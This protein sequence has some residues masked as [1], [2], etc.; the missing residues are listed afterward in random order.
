MVER[1]CALSLEKNEKLSTYP[2]PHLQIDKANV[3][4]TLQRFNIDYPRYPVL[5]LCPGAEFGPSKQWP[6]EHYAALAKKYL[7][8]GWQVFIFGSQKDKVAASHIMQQVSNQKIIDFTGKTNLEEAIDL[9]SLSNMVVSNDSGLMHVAAALHLPLVAVYGSTD[10]NFTPPLGKK[11][12][13]VR[14][15]LQCSPCFQRSCPLVHQ[16]CMQKLKPEMVETAIEKIL[17]TE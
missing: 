16:D 6:P 9:L 14:L 13:I 5:S 4:A 2:L 1:F 7:Q 12:S 8:K 15:G 10:P 17:V 3:A 11:S